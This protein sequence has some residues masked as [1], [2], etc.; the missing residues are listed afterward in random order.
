M[1]GIRKFQK[2]ESRGRSSHREKD[3]GGNGSPSAQ[4]APSSK[5]SFFQT[6]TVF[7]RVS[8]IQRQAS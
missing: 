8:M 2:H 7:L 1:A 5:N 4:V 3:Q 6:G